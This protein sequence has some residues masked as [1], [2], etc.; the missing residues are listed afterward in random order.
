METNCER[1]VVSTVATQSLMLMNS[2]FILA[3]AGYFAARIR[4]EAGGDPSRQVQTAWQFAF[5]RAPEARE[6]ERSLAF[7]AAQTSPAPPPAPPV[8]AGAEKPPAA[9][10]AAPAPT[11][12]LVNLCQVLLS[13]NEFLYVE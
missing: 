4:K 8:A 5:G 6:L 9:E 12:P 2:E 13:T 7:L 11:D 3:Q 10:S 1:R